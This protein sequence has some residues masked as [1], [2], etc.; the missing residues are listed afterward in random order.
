MLGFV[1]G[2]NPNDILTRFI[3]ASLA[4]TV[5]SVHLLA[6]ERVQILESGAGEL[7]TC[8]SQWGIGSRKLFEDNREVFTARFDGLPPPPDTA[9]AED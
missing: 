5:S 2:E 6:R 4:M 3:P 8:L 1:M 7:S 9:E